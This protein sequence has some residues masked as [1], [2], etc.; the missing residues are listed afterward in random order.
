[1]AA[2]VE[3]ADLR[4]PLGCW[5]GTR[6]FTLLSYTVQPVYASRVNG[7]TG[8]ID[9]L[10]GDL[11]TGGQRCAWHLARKRVR[12]VDQ[13]GRE[14]SAGESWP[15]THPRFPEREVF[16]YQA[17]WLRELPPGLTAPAYYG[18]T[19]TPSEVWLWLEW[20]EPA[21]PARLEWADF[22]QVAEA[23]GRWHA[24]PRVGGPKA[25]PWLAAQAVEYFHG[26]T[27]A[28]VAKWVDAIPEGWDHP[29]IRP[30]IPRTLESAWEQYTAIAPRLIA[31]AQALPP[32][33]SHGD[34]YSRNLLPRQQ[35]G[36]R[37]LVA[38]DWACVGHQWLGSDVGHLAAASLAFRDG[39]ET[40]WSAFLAALTDAYVDGLTAA[41][42]SDWRDEARR[43]AATTA[44]LRWAPLGLVDVLSC[45][46]QPVP[47]L[48]E[49]ED[50]RDAMIRHHLRLS[51][52]LLG[53]VLP[54]L[55]PT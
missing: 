2:G 18:H 55:S 34:C 11:I 28:W 52:W 13:F 22:R 50:E 17:P 24:P 43:G 30:W 44:V 16:A 15:Q 25:A 26:V 48:P 53:E 20:I 1:M 3:E 47:W 38:V 42:A 46:G 8:G 40:H 21:R 23:L 36:R 4:R 14:T 31:R 12:R 51:A 19:V 9:H 27:Q 33:L 35:A 39:P 41:G 5:L 6:E 32:V 10:A 29:A 45:L 7:F 54:T 49:A 37:E